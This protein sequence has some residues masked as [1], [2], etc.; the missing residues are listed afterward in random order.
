MHK[1]IL[2]ICRIECYIAKW[3]FLTQMRFSW[4]IWRACLILYIFVDDWE[5]TISWKCLVVEFKIELLMNC[6]L[7]LDIF[8][9]LIISFLIEGFFKRND[10]GLKLFL[11]NT[12]TFSSCIKVLDLNGLGII[13]FFCLFFVALLHHLFLI[14][15][16]F[17]HEW[18]DYFDLNNQQSI[19]LLLSIS[20]E[21]LSLWVLEII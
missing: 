1:S 17:C 13:R 6:K 3:F 8:S 19:W 10:L 5:A 12:L 7:F 21:V 2:H 11:R 9:I 18:L 14:K 16:L 20:Y 15:L 4:R